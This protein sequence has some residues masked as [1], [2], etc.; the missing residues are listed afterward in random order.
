[1]NSTRGGRPSKLTELEAAA[2]RLLWSRRELGFDQAWLA[3][4]FEVNQSQ[5]SRLLAGKHSH[6]RPEPAQPEA[7]AG[8]PALGSGGM[9][10]KLGSVP[11]CLQLKLCEP[12]PF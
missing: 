1:M 9:C 3:R 12:Q 5:V 11:R 7:C 10:A 6:F 2:V 8:A 4:L